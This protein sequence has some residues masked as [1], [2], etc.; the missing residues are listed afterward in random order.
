M[1]YPVGIEALENEMREKDP[2][3]KHRNDPDPEKRMRADAWSVG[4]WLQA[5][6]GLRVSEFLISVA[7]RQIEGEFTIKEAQKL[8]EDYHKS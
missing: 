2:F 8:I 3:E 4:I 7:I 5:V 1:I 6:D